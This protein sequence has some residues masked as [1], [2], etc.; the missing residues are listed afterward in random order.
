MEEE[1]MSNYVCEQLDAILHSGV[2]HDDNPPGRGSGRYEWGTGQRLH[3]HDWEVYDR[4][5]KYRQAGMT[6]KEIVEAMGFK[7]S[8]EFRA[9]K[10]IS[11]NVVKSDKQLTVD[12]YIH[13]TN[14]ETGKVYTPT[15]IGKIM[16][17]NESTVRSIMST[18]GTGNTNKIFQAADTLEMAVKEK[19]YIDVGKGV[20]LSLNLSPDSLNTSLEILKKK[21]YVVD[22]IDVK[23]MIN[24]NQMTTYKVLAMPGTTQQDLRKNKYNIKTLEELSSLDERV[25]NP[26]HPSHFMTPKFLDLK[27]VAFKYDETGGRAMDG[28]IMIK[29][30]K[31]EKGNYIPTNPALSIGNA[32]GAQVRI[33]V[34]TPDGPMYAKGMCGYSSDVPEG[35]DILVWSNKSEEKGYKKAL[36]PMSDSETN[37]FGSAVVQTFMKDKNGNYILDKDG[38][39]QVSAINIVGS[40]PDD[41]H[42]E[43]VWSKWNR[44]TPA[45]FLGKQDKTL[46]KQQL[47]LA[48]QQAEDE[49]SEVMSYTNPTIRK[50]MLIDLADQFDGNAVSLKAAPIAG[51]S[52]HVL[53]AV[54]SLKDT[55]CYCPDLPDGTIVAAV[56][57]PFAGPFES[58]ILRV[59]NR[60]K[61]ARDRLGNAMDFVG[62]NQNVANRLSGADFDGDTATIIPLTRKTASGEF[63]RVTNVKTAPTLPGLEGFDTAEYGLDNPRFAKMVNDKG[64]PTY[65]LIKNTTQRSTQMGIASNLITDMYARGCEDEEELSRAVRYSMVIIDAY[66]HKLNYKAAY[67]DYGIE[68]LKK[69]YQNRVAEDGTEKYGGASS[70]LSRSKSKVQVDARSMAYNIDKETGEKIYRAPKY[71]TKAIRDKQYVEA[72][73]G[74]I[75][76]KTGRKGS[77]Y[78][79]DEDGKKIVATTDGK[80]VKNS[81]GT[82]SYDKGSG[83]EVWV[84][85]GYEKR[86]QDSTQMAE[87]KDARTLLSDNPNEIERMYADFANHMK[88]LANRARLESIRVKED[89]ADPAARKEYAAEVESLKEKLVRAKANSVRE[90]QANLI[91]TS[92]FNA[93][94]NDNPDMDGDEKKKLRGTL[95]KQARFETGAAKNRVRFTDREWEAVEH[96]AISPSMLNDLLKNA[97]EDDYLSRAMPKQDRIGSAKRQRIKAMYNA[98]FTYEEIAKACGVSEGSITGVL[99]KK[100]A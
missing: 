91:A 70:L 2:G 22:T 56:R 96:K 97:D 12:Y 20:E 51:Q 48:I 39:K 82:Y 95:I 93:A 85:K 5:Q 17:V 11:T 46:V 78:M 18:I 47:S 19:H 7:N 87:A 35:Y 84:T 1:V 55:E 83:R 15:E 88:V 66:K 65:K 69:K 27:K 4:I 90:R 10:Q 89:K 60:N 13:T 14:P 73:E 92:R 63:E 37:P 59:N 50:N 68:E 49:L 33:A 36:K 16:G 43:G 31:D 86:K 40:T 41:M 38:N 6:E 57:Y 64:E 53:R 99:N 45:Q 21:G 34:D 42:I 71:T 77:K 80:I 76:P 62:I 44:K 79:V 61:D 94:Y 23:Q 100:S 26:D 81:D 28:E 75:N 24:P 72:P 9:V 8:N 74:Y 30:E 3:Q 32:R 67:E 25:Q 54:P 29:A 58:P 98:G 52:V